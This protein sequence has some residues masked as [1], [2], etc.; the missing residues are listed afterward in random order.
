MNYLV[1]GYRLVP[2]WSAALLLCLEC[3]LFLWL[4]RA[5]FLA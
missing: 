2:A 3:L 1:V 5:S 4:Q